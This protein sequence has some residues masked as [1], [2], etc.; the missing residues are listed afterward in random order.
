MSSKPEVGEENAQGDGLEDGLDLQHETESREE[1]SDVAAESHLNVDL[2]RD[3]TDLE[4]GIPD[5]A[6]LEAEEIAETAGTS[7]LQQRRTQSV[8]VMLAE[9]TRSADETSS[10]PDDTPSI[11]ASLPSRVV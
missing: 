11:Q 10:G 7:S 5:T 8:Q 4:D 2:G 9:D 3:E 6:E 1:P